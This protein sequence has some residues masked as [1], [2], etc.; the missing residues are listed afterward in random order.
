VRAASRARL[1]GI[2]G[3]VIDGDVADYHHKGGRSRPGPGWFS[4]AGW[5]LI[6][7]R[8]SAGPASGSWTCGSSPAGAPVAPADGVSLLAG[9]GWGVSGV[10]RRL[11]SRLRWG[12]CC[13]R[14]LFP[15]A[16]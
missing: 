11:A 7:C 1:P 13:M 3:E 16:A 2:R 5:V 15:P 14:G 9:P 8:A 12:A 6:T 4:A 10:L